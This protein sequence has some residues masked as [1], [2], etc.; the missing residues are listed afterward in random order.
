MQTTC[1]GAERANTS[2][3][4]SGSGSSMIK[5]QSFTRTTHPPVSDRHCR[6]A[7]D[8][9]RN[10]PV[11]TGRPAGS[12][13]PRTSALRRLRRTA[14]NAG[15]QASVCAAR[16][17]QTDHSHEPA[18]RMSAHRYADRRLHRAYRHGEFTVYFSGFDSPCTRFRISSQRTA[19]SPTVL[20][21]CP[22]VS[23]SHRRR[24]RRISDKASQ[25]PYLP[26]RG[27]WRERRCLRQL[28]YTP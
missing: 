8:A 25:P 26:R 14:R 15:S 24:S 27:A 2:G 11:Q 7:H 12:R 1:V 9:M 16:S 3:T 4:P 18:T 20:R 19:M 13:G 5:Q 10:A 23:R 17:P 28:D 6:P 22:L 21:C